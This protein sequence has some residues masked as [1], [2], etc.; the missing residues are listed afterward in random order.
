MK[1]CERSSMKVIA[2]TMMIGLAGVLGQVGCAQETVDSGGLLVIGG[3]DDLGGDAAGI[4]SISLDKYLY[5]EKDAFWFTK[6]MTHASASAN[7]A[8]LIRDDGSHINVN[9]L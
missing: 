2:S 5:Q 7:N 8:F 9:E 6:S 3:D 1:S 4:Y